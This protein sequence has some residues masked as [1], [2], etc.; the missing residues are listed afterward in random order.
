MQQSKNV[1]FMKKDQLYRI[2]FFIRNFKC[3]LY[4]LLLFYTF[5]SLCFLFFFFFEANFLNER[6]V[7]KTF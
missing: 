4:F 2:V 7:M 6:S 3:I 5:S 1:S